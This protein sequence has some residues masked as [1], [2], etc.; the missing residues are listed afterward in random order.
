[1]RIV[2]LAQLL[3]KKYGLE[4]VAGSKELEHRVNAVRQDILDA[5]NNYINIESRELKPAY[6][7][8]PLLSEM[9]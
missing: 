5:Y 9:V 1:M 8:I 2:R 6:N 3:E 7:I 4:A